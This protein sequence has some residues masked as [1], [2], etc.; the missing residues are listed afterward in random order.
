VNDRIQSWASILLGAAVVVLV[1]WLTMDQME[2]SH[3]RR[4]PDGGSA[5]SG[6]SSA[7]SASTADIANGAASA[8]PVASLGL[9]G[10]AA[11]VDSAGGSAL[12]AIDTDGG[13]ALGS[14]NSLLSDGGA[15]PSGAPRTVRLGVVLVQYVGA[16]GAS[17]S[18]RAK[19]DALAHAQELAT[20][21]HADWRAAVKAGDSGSS[22]DIGRIPRGVLDAHTEVAVFSLAKDE[23]SEPLETP[24]GYWIVK[25]VE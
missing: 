12:G 25:R 6:A 15:L 21:A 5:S 8:N 17:R 2:R 13:F 22:E 9:G 23:I 18:A 4:E 10:S 3:I 19:P 11:P 16:E 14:L 7:S 20:Q 24:R 1:G